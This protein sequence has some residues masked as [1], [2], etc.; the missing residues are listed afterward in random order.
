V[1]LGC[2]IG[3]ALPA[4][5]SARVLLVGSYR[6][7]AGDYTGIQ[8]AVDAAHPGD[9]ILIGPGDHKETG[10]RV[11]AGAAGDD[12]AGAAVLITTPGLHLR[13]MNR[14]T[15]V[16]DGTKAGT[17]PC[18]PAPA[19]QDLGP[20]TAGGTPTGRNGIVVYEADGTSIENLSACNFLTG[21]QGGGNLIWWDGG[22][23]SGGQ[24][25]GSFSGAYL[26]ATS[27][28]N[29]G[30]GSPLSS[31][32]I[33]AS[34]TYGPG[35]ITRTYASNMG[36]SAY[37]V[38]A[39]P[40]CNVTLDRAH[41]AFSDLGYSG[42]NSGG[43]L[44]VENSEF[45]HNQSGFVTNS[46]NNDDAPS[47]QDGACPGGGTGPTGSHS[48]WVFRGNYVH[49]NNNPNVP[50]FGPAALAPVGSGVVIAGG[51]NDTVIDNR[52]TGNGAWGILAIP[53]P[54]IGNPPDVAH[55]TGG[56][57]VPLGGLLGSQSACYFDDFGNEIARNTLAGNGTFGNATN[58]DLAEASNLED[59]GNCWHDNV[60]AAGVGGTVTSAP[61]LLQFT[62]RLCGVPNVGAAFVSPLGLN[63]ICDAQFLATLIPGIACPSVPSLLGL[64]ALFDYPRATNVVFAPLPRQPTM[65]RPCRGTPASRWCP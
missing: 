21:D 6:G 61:P 16:V 54:D 48:C 24:H 15:V 26:S 28:F 34:N 62:H 40:D 35:T 59:P 38:G 45:D 37:Y 9:W 2:V 17:P 1:L 3:L 12:R 7:V 56:T 46:Q 49:D 65:S 14:N 51:R 31:Y 19:D 39:C 30:A 58:A 8:A 10:T 42:T 64:P 43:H 57:Y 27:T 47:P 53:F 52:V 18:S 22:G 60:R 13:G 55:C 29:G 36:D 23:G 5:A 20:A 50:T 32:G 11:P 41:G 4:S 25:L 33:Y 63:V 44:I